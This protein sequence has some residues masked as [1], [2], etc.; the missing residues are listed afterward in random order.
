[1]KEH[2]WKNKWIFSLLS[3]IFMIYMTGCQKEYSFE[4]SPVPVP[5]TLPA[6]TTIDFPS[7]TSCINNDTLAL[8]SWKFKLN[9]AILCG[10]SDTAI[11][12]IERSSFT[13]FG[14]SSCSMDSGL[15]ITVYLNPWVLDSDQ[16]NISA[17]MVAFYY[18]DHVGTSY[19]LMSQ[20]NTAFSLTIESYNNLTGLTVGKFSGYAFMANGDFA[21][22]SEG[23]F[24]VK[25][26]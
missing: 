17:G 11:I 1:M 7:C 22:V 9:N 4:G 19:I 13:F 18:Y 26:R 15:V 21:T 14:P 25:L 5:D 6:T 2:W 8:W 10:H 20:P 23:R 16:S 24:K 12:N 3:I